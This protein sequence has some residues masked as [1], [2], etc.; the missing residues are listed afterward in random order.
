[1]TRNAIFGYVIESEDFHTEGVVGNNPTLDDLHKALGKALS[2]RSEKPF[3]F[4]LGI[5]DGS[6]IEITEQHDKSLITNII[7]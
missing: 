3:V 5:N 7:Q 6:I 1:M 2:E 4:R